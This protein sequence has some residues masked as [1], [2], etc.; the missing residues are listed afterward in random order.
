MCVC[1]RAKLLPWLEQLGAASAA[2]TVALAG[3][4]LWGV[5]W[6]TR[7]LCLNTM[8]DASLGCGLFVGRPRAAAA[9]Q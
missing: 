4:V 2:C 9:L 3:A 8:A 5:G 7:W 6:L 1:L